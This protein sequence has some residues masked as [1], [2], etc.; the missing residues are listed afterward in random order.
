M[1]ASRRRRID[2]TPEQ[3]WEAISTIDGLAK[4][5][6]GAESASHTGGPESGVG[7]K[8]TVRRVLYSHDV[9]VEQEVV[10]W[11]PPGY[12]RFSHLRETVEGREVRGVRNF[13][14]TILLSPLEDATQVEIE[15]TWE[16][17]FGISW[18]QSLLLGGRVLGRDL[19]DML[20]KIETLVT[21]GNG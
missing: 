6:A 18:F 17:G 9:D 11:D 19:T 2:A 7:R 8:Q 14:T 15:Y 3:I 10:G 1:K 21:S 12:L 16:T 4:W 20:K 5:F 13:H